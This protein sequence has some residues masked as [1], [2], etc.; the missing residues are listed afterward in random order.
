[1]SETP[2]NQ[3][4]KSLGQLE[5]NIPPSLSK[6]VRTAISCLNGMSP[7]RAD[8]LQTWLSVGMALKTIAGEDSE[9]DEFLGEW[10]EKWSSQSYKYKPG[11][12]RQRWEKFNSG[13]YTLG[14]LIHLARQDGASIQTGRRKV[15][16][17]TFRLT[18]VIKTGFPEWVEREISVADV[19]P[20]D[21]VAVKG[22]VEGTVLE[23]RHSLVERKGGG[24]VAVEDNVTLFIRFDGIDNIRDI[25]EVERVLT[26]EKTITYAYGHS[27]HV[28]RRQTTPDRIKRYNGRDKEIRPYHRDTHGE[29][30]VGKGST[31][32]PLYRQDE[33]EADVANGVQVVF[34]LAGEQ[35]VE[36]GRRLG[37]TAFTNQGGEAAGH[38]QII[39]FLKALRC[40]LFAIW[41][42]NDATGEATAERLQSACRKAKIPCVVV[43]PHAIWEDMP[44]KGDITDVY[45]KSGLSEEEILSRLE[46]H[47]RDLLLAPEKEKEGKGLPATSELAKELADKYRSRMA[48][49][50]A[51]QIWYVY[52]VEHNGLWSKKSKESVRQLVQSELEHHPLNT[53][54]FNAGTINST[55]S[56]LEAHLHI[57]KWNE[58]DRYL[59]LR[60]GVLDIESGEFLNHSPD[61][62]FTWQLPYEYNPRATCERIQ[63]WMLEAMN[64]D[65]SLVRLLIAWLKAVVCGRTDMQRFLECVGPASTGKSTFIR[66]AT[67]IVGVENTFATELKH[68]EGNRFESA[69]IYG[70]RLVEITDSERYTGSVS[71]LKA[72]TG[73]DAIRYEQKFQ[74]QINSF[75]PKAMVMVAANESIQSADY[76]SGLQRRRLTIPFINQ[77]KPDQRRD[78]ITITDSSVSGEF[79]EELSGLLNLVL[80]VSEQEMVD[81]L[82]NTDAHVPSLK[83]WKSEVLVDSNPIADWLDNCCVFLPGERT[84]VGKV[85]KD[86]FKRI[87]NTD[88]W[89]Y[90]N[91]VAY[92]EATGSNAVKHNRFTGLLEDLLRSQLMRT[93]VKRGKDSRGSYF[94]GLS[95]RTEWMDLDK[96]PRP[97]TGGSDGLSDGLVTAGTLAYDGL[98]GNDGLFLTNAREKNDIFPENSKEGAKNGFEIYKR[99]EEVRQV[100]G[101]PHTKGFQPSQGPSQSITESVTRQLKEGD[102]VRYTGA[103]YGGQYNNIALMIAQLSGRQASCTTPTG[104]YTT[105]LPISELRL[106]N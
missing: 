3:A 54:G 91:Y 38:K 56:Q 57:E 50:T 102:R 66:L 37:L 90:P 16:P 96:Y 82:R 61:Y 64:G 86:E 6:D 31:Q 36:A 42:D 106:V 97:I 11:E 58:E 41:A 89:L 8:E 94:E 12:P 59:P 105:W 65:K 14:T 9:L 104:D 99:V 72:L 88:M 80:S 34:Y 68:L 60:N 81:L 70:K 95:L 92:C 22:G 17:E 21:Q 18:R 73:Q 101:V 76:T 71:L 33:V 35:A 7:Q 77:V 45:E 23:R 27:C 29:W 25:S 44:L 49:N 55:I 51:A 1:M 46:Q 74:Q 83:R 40:E 30:V 19:Q 103:R 98:D 32:W 52:G 5:D 24:K 93:D 4:E 85:I 100:R 79:A 26:R 63:G 53:K 13:C 20:V 43:D 39:E 75:V 47:I 87:L 69:G 78:L 15:D 62:R 84:N 2:S 10:F 67:A 28:V 48:W